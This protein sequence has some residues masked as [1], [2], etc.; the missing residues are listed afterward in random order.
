MSFFILGAKERVKKDH[1]LMRID[2]LINWHPIEKTLRGIHVNEINPK[3]GPKAYNNLSMFKAILLGQWHSL[4]DPGLEEAI[5]L[6]LD[7]MLFTGFEIGDET[8]DETTL[9]RFRN[10]LIER[11]LHESLFK[12]INR[13]LEEHGIKVRKAEAALVD[14]TIIASSARP[15]STIEHPS[16]E[17]KRSADPDA[18]W[19][20]K[21]NRSYFGYRG[22]VITDGKEGFIHHLSVTPANQSE[23][24]QFPGLIGHLHGRRVLTD[25]GFSSLENR[26]ELKKQ[27][28]KSGISH[29]ATRNHPLRYSQRLFNRIVAKRRFRI[30]QAFGTLKR[31]FKMDRA[32]YLGQVKV[33]G[34]LYWKAICFNLTKAIRKVSVV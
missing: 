7:F 14:A 17:V 26:E 13:Q 27:G 23:M 10:K 30:E 24:K 9:C 22:Y 31:R 21:G 20:T 15:R 18:T 2:R 16:G 12:E 33:E 25:K 4:S 11:K 19:V 32:G 1:Y 3:G 5:R 29:K 8:P 34:Q 28:I 6:R